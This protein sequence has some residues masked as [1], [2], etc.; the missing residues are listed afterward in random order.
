M[1]ANGTL[2]FLMG[3]LFLFFGYLGR[4]GRLRADRVG[5]DRGH[6]H[7]DQPRLDDG[8]AVQRH[9][10]RGAARG[11]VLPAGRRPDDVGQRHR[12]HDPAVADHGRAFARR[13]RPGGDAVQHVL[14]R[15]FRLVGGRRRGTHAHARAGD[16]SRGLRQR[17][18][19]RAHRLGRDHGQSHSAQHHGGGLRRDRQRLDRRAVPRR[20]R[21]GRAGRHRIDDLQLFFRPGRPQAQTRDLWPIQ[22]GG[23]RR[24][25]CR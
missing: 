23:A 14:R 9:G 21:A 24:P 13:A 11:A 5:A 1:T 8:A 20:R 19:R 25:W 2:I 15:H 17:L 3:F 6:L 4:A 22:H 18:Y 10:R 7:A 16:E 12:A